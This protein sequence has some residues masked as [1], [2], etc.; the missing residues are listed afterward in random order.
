MS[1]VVTGQLHVKEYKKKPLEKFKLFTHFQIF[2]KFNRLK[3]V[4]ALV[5]SVFNRLTAVRVLVGSIF[6]RLMM[7]RVLVG[8]PLK[9]VIQYALL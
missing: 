1:D 2:K 5:G 8:I 6:N 7:V 4:R 3:M 9:F